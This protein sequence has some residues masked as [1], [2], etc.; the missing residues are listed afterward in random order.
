MWSNVPINTFGVAYQTKSGRENDVASAKWALAVAIAQKH[1]E[2]A[3]NSGSSTCPPAVGR[4]ARPGEIGF[5][6]GP[7][8]TLGFLAT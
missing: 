5:F 1:W 6:V 8:A 3:V 7:D 4:L 2:I